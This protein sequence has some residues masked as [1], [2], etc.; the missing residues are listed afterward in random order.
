MGRSSAC[1]EGF[2]NEYVMEFWRSASLLGYD[3]PAAMHALEAR[4]RKQRSKELQIRRFR[5]FSIIMD[6]SNTVSSALGIG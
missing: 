3:L 6:G 4:P 1:W 5:T 2:L